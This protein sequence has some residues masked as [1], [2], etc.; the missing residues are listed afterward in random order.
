VDLLFEGTGFRLLVELKVGS[1]FG[2]NQIKR[3]ASAGRRVLAVV[4]DS[5]AALEAVGDRAGPGWLG[6]CSW[7]R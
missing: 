5:D 7:E 4:R 2:V 6:A 3:Y 1:D